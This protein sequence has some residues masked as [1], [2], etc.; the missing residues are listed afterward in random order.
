M[1]WRSSGVAMLLAIVSGLAPGITDLHLD[2]RIVNRRQIVDR[3]L[4]VTQHA[5]QDH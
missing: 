2:N 4:K 5:K 1:N 3:Q